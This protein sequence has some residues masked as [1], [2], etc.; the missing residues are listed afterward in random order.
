MNGTGSRNAR[1]SRPRLLARSRVV[2]QALAGWLR[3]WFTVRLTVGAALSVA[4]G[5]ALGVALGVALAGTSSVAMAQ[6]PR[7]TATRTMSPFSALAQQR[8]MPSVID[9]TFDGAARVLARYK[10][11]P[12]PSYRDTPTEALDGRVFSQEPVAGQPIPIP[13][14]S[15]ALG[16]YR[17]VRVDSIAV[18][19]VTGIPL[20]LAVRQLQRAGLVPRF[21]RQGLRSAA[22]AIVSAQEPPAGTRV[23]PGATVTLTVDV[24]TRVPWV[25]GSDVATAT[26]RL[27]TQGLVLEPRGGDYSDS[28]AAGR[29]VRQ[30]PDSGIAARPG[31]VV[32]VWTSLGQHPREPER[33]MPRLVG[34]SLGEASAA[35]APLGLAVTHVD[36]VIDATGTGRITKQDPPEGALV[37]TSDQVDVQLAVPPQGRRVPWVVGRTLPE[38]AQALRDAGFTPRARLVPAGE[39][40]RGVI[41]AQSVDSVVVRPPRTLV[42][43][44]AT[45]TVGPPPPETR[46]MPNVVG[47]ARDEAIEAL[48][49]L[50]PA[51][52]TVA[53]ATSR[54]EEENRVVAQAPP[55]GAIVLPGVDVVLRVGRFVSVPPPPDSLRQRD[56]LPTDSAIVPAVEGLT[57]GEARAPLARAG[58]V[59]GDVTAAA[60]VAD[61]IIARQ[62]PVAGTAV[63]R[64]STVALTLRSAQGDTNTTGASVSRNEGRGGSPP[65]WLLIGAGGVVAAVVILR[66]R[67]PSRPDGDKDEDTRREQEAAVQVTLRPSPLPPPAVKLPDEQAVVAHEVTLV[68]RE[69][70]CSVE[71]PGSLIVREEVSN[72]RPR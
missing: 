47:M 13:P 67:R 42:L 19:S 49:F 12:A 55:V 23:A 56:S 34:L 43:L 46:D 3:V 36:S 61:S 2:R 41:I 72:G 70:E 54:K 16:V 31:E 1:A 14:A 65:W 20:L 6:P 44:T 52:R 68:D 45:D 66:L 50:S 4:L 51:L 11:T 53:E 57:M 25:V 40:A 69:P 18:P 21:S 30:H 37:H 62:S 64:G 32:A 26:Q 59:L 35:L 27:A 63:A 28:I 10:L 15:I 58:L 48:K 7:P 5:A 8:R 17:Y 9:S 24:S 29:I 22:V 39:A 60:A 38:G 71:F 33:L